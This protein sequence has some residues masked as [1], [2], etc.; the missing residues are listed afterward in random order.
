MGHRGENEGLADADDDWGCLGM[1]FCRGK[2]L[3]VGLDGSME[4]RGGVFDVEARSQLR[5][6]QDVEAKPGSKGE[7]KRDGSRRP[8]Q[9]DRGRVGSADPKGTG[10]EKEGVLSCRVEAGTRG[11]AMAPAGP[12]FTI[13]GCGGRRRRPGGSPSRWRQVGVAI[14]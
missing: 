8:G 4:G 1:G 5:E 10:R 6:M 14:G 13:G 7:S 9:V 12:T 3:L 2:E 11:G